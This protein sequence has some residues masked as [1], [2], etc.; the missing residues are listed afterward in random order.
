MRRR[1]MRLGTGLAL[2]WSAVLPQ[3]AVA[4][5]PP[6]PMAPTSKWNLDYAETECRLMRS[7]GEGKNEVLFQISRYD[8]IDRWDMGLAGPRFPVTE[9][10]QPVTVSTS[11]VAE[12]PGMMAQGFASS[13]DAPAT[14]RFRPDV[15]L[16]KAF[17]S[18][19]VAGKPT[20]LGIRFAH[21]YA[22]QFDLGPMAGAIA[23]LDKCSD[24][25]IASWGLDPAQQRSL[26][27]APEPLESPAKWF[28]PE[29]YPAGLS[30]MGMGGAV[31]IRLLVGADGSV[32]KCQVTKS[33][34]DKAFQDATCKAAM[35]RA[36]FRPAIAADGQPSASV[37]IKRVNWKPGGSFIIIR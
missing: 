1:A 6:P 12:V 17:R 23:A 14:L 9:A 4:A 15:D 21:R 26:K 16:P 30:R 20:I 19:I 28:R 10:N 25:L 2:S 24:N 5:E 18:D 34:G 33:G 31:I 11:T 13:H 8:L 35:K 32:Q 3:I 29:D 22:A 7:F 27:S 37:W 36:R